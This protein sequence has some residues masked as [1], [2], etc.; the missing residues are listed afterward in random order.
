MMRQQ[1]LAPK[2][3]CDVG[4]GAGLVLAE[5]QPYLPSDCVCWGYDV[6]PDALAMSAGAVP[7]TICVFACA[8]YEKTSAIPI[9]ICC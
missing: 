6:S 5:L 4:C 9:L 7:T 3:V 1:N 2:A 8:T